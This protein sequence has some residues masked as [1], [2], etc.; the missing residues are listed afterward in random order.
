MLHGNALALPFPDRAVDV[1]IC[2]LA[3]HHFPYD[4]AV[5]VLREIARVARHG[6]IVNDILRSWGAYLGAWLDTRLLSR[7][8]L[9]RHDGPLSVLRSFTVDEFRAM[10]TQAGLSGVEVRRHPMFRVALIR[11][12]PTRDPPRRPRRLGAER[13]NAES[14]TPAPPARGGAR[15]RETVSPRT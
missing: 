10:V 8:R 15:E 2:G 9:A 12:P 4:E 3:L 11:W 13:G 5:R 7:N 6:F 1:V 14:P